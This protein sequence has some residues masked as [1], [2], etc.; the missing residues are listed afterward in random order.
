MKNT[1]RHCGKVVYPR[2]LIKGNP[3]TI[4]VPDY[5]S[6]ECKIKYNRLIHKI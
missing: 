4:L 2:E 1:C 6:P 3:K 5:C